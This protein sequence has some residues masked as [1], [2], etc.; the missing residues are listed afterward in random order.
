MEDKIPL[1]WISSL[2][3]PFRNCNQIFAPTFATSFVTCIRDIIFQRI[4][5]MSEKELKEVDKEIIGRLLN[6]VKDFL[7]LSFSEMETAELIE[8]TQLFVAL[9]FLKSTYLEKRLKGLNDLK[10]LIEKVNA[11]PHYMNKR[12]TQD[13]DMIGFGSGMSK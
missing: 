4:K 12:R 10:T 5:T 8:S 13:Q 11:I 6:D 1:D 7:L 2:T 9:R 3:A